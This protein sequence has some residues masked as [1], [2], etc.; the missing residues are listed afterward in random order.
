MYGGELIDYPDPATFFM[1]GGN[2]GANGG[3]QQGMLGTLTGGLYNDYMQSGNMED[4]FNT[5]SNPNVG[6]P[7]MEKQIADYI[8]L[9][10]LFN[11]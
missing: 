11:K 3:P 4:F 7:P 10:S 6:N 1:G 5:Y 2:M 8:Y 9:R